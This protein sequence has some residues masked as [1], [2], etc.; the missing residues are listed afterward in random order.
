MSEYEYVEFRAVDRPLTD[1]ELKY[2]RK[3][4]TRADISRWSFRNEYHFGDFDGDVNGLLRHGYDVHLHYANF[5]IRTIAFR[6]PTG[7]PFLKSV[8]SRYIGTE[9]LRWEQDRS[10]KGGIISLSP[11]RDDIEPLWDLGNYMD[12]FVTIRNQ[13]VT[14]DLRALYAFWLCAAMDDNCDVDDIVEPPVPAG[15]SQCDEAFD[16]LMEFFSLD[17]LM[18][19]AAAEGTLAAPQRASDDQQVRRWVEQLSE[20]DSRELLIRFLTEQPDAVKNETIAAIRNR[21]E[22]PDW[23]TTSLGRSIA[24]LLDRTSQLQADQQ[25]K[26]QKEQAAA[27]ERAEAQKEQERQDRMKKM[28]K[29]PRAWLQ[30][31]SK[32]AEQRGTTNYK[33]AAD[34]LADLREAIGGSEGEKL[35]RQHAAHLLKKYPTLTH[36]KSSLRKRG[37]VE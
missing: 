4:S 3:Q 9:S 20:A 10:G 21:G 14:G 27:A 37:L 15:L 17:P 31:A 1:A 26:E 12:D 6:L 32:L 23:P 35:T 8:W 16:S 13:L 5:G 18:L 34:I 22:T 7:L 24:A 30:E 29:E 11:F 2:A 25:A 19:V 36:L 33:A 28:V